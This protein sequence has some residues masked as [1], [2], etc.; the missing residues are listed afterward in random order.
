MKKLAL[1]LLLGVSLIVVTACSPAG[2]T[3]TSSSESTTIST[4]ER[5]NVD[6]KVVNEGQEVANQELETTETTSLL[7]IMEKE[8]TLEVDNGMIISIDG[9]KQDEKAGLYWTYTI[10]SEW[11]EKGAG[12]TFLKDGD[13]IEFTYGKFE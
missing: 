8:H 7:D 6:L 1:S 4:Q 3:S 10:N 12:E 13:Q 9:T 2:N 11:A 5:I